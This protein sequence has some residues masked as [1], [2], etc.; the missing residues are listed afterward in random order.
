MLG[1]PGALVSFDV[2][3]R[4]SLW[5][6]TGSAKATY[7]AWQDAPTSCSPASAD[8]A[9]LITGH[10]DVRRQLDS[11]LESGVQQAIVKQGH[12]GAVAATSDGEFESRPAIEVPVIDTV[13]AGDAFVAGWLAELA[14]G[15]SL[16]ARLETAVACGALACTGPG[17]WEANPTRD[18]V[19]RLH[20]TDP[21]ELLTPR[22]GRSVWW[23]Y[24]LNTG[25]PSTP[26]R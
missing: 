8:E 6:D 22:P 21:R 14:R 23:R 5:A 7:R 20:R 24:E 1:L 26:S 13:G 25:C 18:D 2:N 12:R 3:H 4:G 19:A 17:D 16:G 11:L 15:C 9:G 10:H